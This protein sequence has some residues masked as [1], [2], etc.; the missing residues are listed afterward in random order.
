MSKWP[1]LPKGF[2][3][4]GGP[5]RVRMVKK[6]ETHDGTACWGTWEPSTRIIRIV[7]SAPPQHRW[8]VYFHEW[9]HSCL[10]DSGIAQQLSDAGQEALCEAYATARMAEMHA[11]RAT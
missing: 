5:V 6:E 2:H 1:A 9:M 11:E 3:G 8:R 10:D 4:A 7:R